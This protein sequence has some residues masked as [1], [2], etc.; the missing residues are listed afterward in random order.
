M[1]VL[2]LGG[3]GAMGEFLAKMLVDAG[4]EVVVTSR[5]R[6]GTDAGV[7]F[8][9]GNAR[10]PE[11][12]RSLLESR[13][14]VIVDFMIYT[15]AEFQERN[16]LLLGA[17]GQYVFLSSARVYAESS[18]PL[19]EA[20]PRLLDVSC[21]EKFLETDEYALRKARQEDVLT[22]SDRSNW[23]IVRPYI[24]YGSQRFQLGVLEKEAWLYRALRGRSIVFSE[25]INERLTTLTHGRDVSAGIMALLGRGEVLGEAFHIASGSPVKWSEV[26]SIY[27]DVIEEHQ[28]FRPTVLLQDLERFERIHRGHYQVRYDRLYD[29][30]FDCSKI[31]KY[32]D[33][34]TFTAVGRGLHECMGTFLRS[35]SFEVIDWRAEA[36]KDRQ[37]REGTQLSEISGYRKKLRYLYYRYL[38]K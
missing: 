34:G 32:V 37:A 10:N 5:R 15:T 31:G 6:R 4:E 28:G 18:G 14:D 38:S 25:D 3:T 20:S 12:L 21:D 22:A 29:R 36:R 27:L 1:R 7:T 33:T 17:T 23:T 35:P 11:F 24:T 9:T 13:W 30:L 26:L 8:A 2:L 19:R 16:G